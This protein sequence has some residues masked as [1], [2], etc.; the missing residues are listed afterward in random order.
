MK[1]ISNYYGIFFIK[2]N[3][4]VIDPH[5]FCLHHKYFSSEVILF[6]DFLFIKMSYFVK[7]IMWQ[8]LCMIGK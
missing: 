7:L 6:K 3:E 2:L 1:N 4:Y 8:K 5:F